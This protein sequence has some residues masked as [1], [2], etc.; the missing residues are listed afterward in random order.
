MAVRAIIAC[1]LFFLLPSPTARAETVAVAD[2]VR[3]PRLDVWAA[4]D[5]RVSPKMIWERF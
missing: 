5:C 2:C 1:F 3:D 4:A